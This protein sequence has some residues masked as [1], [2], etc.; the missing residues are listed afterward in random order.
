MRNTFSDEIPDHDTPEEA[1]PTRA[2]MVNGT[3]ECGLLMLSMIASLPGADS[4]FGVVLVCGWVSEI[5]E[6]SIAEVLRDRAAQT[7]DLTGATRLEGADVLMP[8][9]TADDLTLIEPCREY[10]E[11][12]SK[13]GKSARIIIQTRSISSTRRLSR[14]PPK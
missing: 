2:W 1:M 11:R 12:L 4:A 13:A 9:V 3:F 10:A 7:L 6:H 8:H 5:G 14:R